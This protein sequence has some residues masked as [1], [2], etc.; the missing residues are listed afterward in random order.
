MAA[1]VLVSEKIKLIGSLLGIDTEYASDD[2]NKTIWRYLQLNDWDAERASSAILDCGGLMEASAKL[3]LEPVDA[4]PSKPPSKESFFST[5]AA[6]S[7]SSLPQDRSTSAKR[8]RT[9]SVPED[10]PAVPLTE[11]VLASG[12][13][14]ELTSSFASLITSMR[15]SIETITAQLPAKVWCTVLQA[16]FEFPPSL[17]PSLPPSHVSSRNLLCR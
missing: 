3:R 11:E 2:A 17:P 13:S 8:P 7:S 4:A 12:G 10:V 14:V 15:T 5:F 6:A 16:D 1:P 9:P